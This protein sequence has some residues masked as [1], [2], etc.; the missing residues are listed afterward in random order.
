MR[1]DTI[2]RVFHFSMIVVVF[3][4]MLSSIW[5]VAPEPGK[6]VNLQMMFFT[7]HVWLFGWAA[8][9]LGSTFAMIKYRDR[10]DWGRYFPWFYSSR[11][12]AL[13][14]AVC[15]EVPDMFKGRLQPAESKSPLSGAMHGLAVLLLI[16]QGLTGAYV[17]LDLANYGTTSADIQLFFKF[18]ELLGIIVW[19]FLFSHVFMTL[20]HLAVGHNNILDIFRK[21][22]I[23]WK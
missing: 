5:M 18:H 13:Y 1:F 20:F 16:G 10:D 19:V 15:K 6:M 9:L 7:L 14:A 2:T 12:K 11:R 22:S 8:F 17:M 21:V 4:Q 23:N 3:Y